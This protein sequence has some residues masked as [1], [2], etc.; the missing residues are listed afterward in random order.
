MTSSWLWATVLAL[1]LAA[2]L[3]AGE[4]AAALATVTAGFVT[5]IALIGGGA[6]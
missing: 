2:R 3:V 1:G 6:G 4:N 5:G